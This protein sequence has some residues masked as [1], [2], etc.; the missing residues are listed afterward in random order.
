MGAS[1]DDVGEKGGEERKGVVFGHDGGN[2]G[3]EVGDVVGEGGVLE[4]VEEKKREN[5]WDNGSEN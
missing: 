2:V 4:V 1:I 5:V 3:G